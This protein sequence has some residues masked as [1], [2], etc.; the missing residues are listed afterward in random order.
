M[1]GE[2]GEQGEQGR[3]G[4]SA[5]DGAARLLQVQVAW[6][7]RESGIGR[8]KSEARRVFRTSRVAAV[9]V[10]GFRLIP[11]SKAHTN[12]RQFNKSFWD[13][14]HNFGFCSYIYFEIVSTC[15]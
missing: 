10:S 6:R 14:K 9:G 15:R 4:R 13:H 11:L 12:E 2:Y 8:L 5:R 1:E 3:A 7:V